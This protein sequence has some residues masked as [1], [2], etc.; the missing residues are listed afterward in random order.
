LVHVES[1]R[2]EGARMRRFRGGVD[3]AAVAGLVLAAR[4]KSQSNLTE[5]Y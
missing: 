1:A 3:V 5:S 4:P 2:R